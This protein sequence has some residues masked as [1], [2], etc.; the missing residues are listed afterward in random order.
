M[1]GITFNTSYKKKPQQKVILYNMPKYVQ[2]PA[3]VQVPVQ[4]PVQIPVQVPA[5]VSV[6]VH[7]PLQV[8]IPEVKKTV[9]STNSN[10]SITDKIKEQYLKKNIIT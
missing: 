4:I 2:V 1:S 8:P 7:V 5:P 9:I 6:P 3:P 10:I